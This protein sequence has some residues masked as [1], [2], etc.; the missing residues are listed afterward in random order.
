MTDYIN[1]EEAILKEEYFVEKYRND[2][3]LILNKIKTGSVG[4][5]NN[6][7]IIYWTKEKCK[8]ESL[9][10]ISRYSFQKNSSGAY[11]SARKNKWLDEICYHMKSKRYSTSY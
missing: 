2:G 9:K 7:H 5:Y 8:I 1:V 3:F 4:G 10:Y 11:S 6:K